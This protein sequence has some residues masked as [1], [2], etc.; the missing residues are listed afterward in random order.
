MISAITTVDDTTKNGGWHL[1]FLFHFL[2][3]MNVIDWTYVIIQQYIGTYWN[4]QPDHFEIGL[5]IPQHSSQIGDTH[6]TMITELW[7]VIHGDISTTSRPAM[8]ANGGM[9]G[10]HFHV[11][12]IHY[13]KGSPLC[14]FWWVSVHVLD[15][16]IC[17]YTTTIYMYYTYIIYITY[18]IYIYAYTLYTLYTVNIQT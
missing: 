10:G 7:I 5:Y 17:M 2:D 11:C 15:T 16:Y 6:G 18:T 4:Y 9:Y 13:N 1:S 12:W 3:K 8:W 14:N